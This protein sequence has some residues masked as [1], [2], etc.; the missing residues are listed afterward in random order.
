[1]QRLIEHQREQ[2]RKGS[3][4]KASNNNNDDGEVPD[5]DIVKYLVQIDEVNQK[6]SELEFMLS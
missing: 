1:M 6:N 3:I 5:D 4:I 2:F